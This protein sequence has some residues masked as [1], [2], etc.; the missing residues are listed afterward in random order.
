MTLL[1]HDLAVFWPSHV[2][3]SLSFLN[4]YILNVGAFFRA[5]LAMTVERSVNRGQV[6]DMFGYAS[7]G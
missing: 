3:W 5:G 7:G 1:V 2:R 6:S 4:V